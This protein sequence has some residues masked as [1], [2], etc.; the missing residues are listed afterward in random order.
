MRIKRH[1]LHIGLAVALVLVLL[2]NIASLLWYGKVSVAASG[3]TPF[4]VVIANQVLTQNETKKLR[5]GTYAA[6]IRG[7]RVAKIEQKITVG[8]FSTT[9]ISNAVPALTNE[10]LIANLTGIAKENLKLYAVEFF[11]EE[12]WLVASVGL[13][14]E[15]SDTIPV[16]AKYA[17]GEWVSIDSGTG[18]EY[19]D[20]VGLPSNVRTYLENRSNNE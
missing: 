8:A 16:I 1:Q 6:T 5:P 13:L 11:N 19:G 10:D 20:I 15:P 18:I 4:E 17:A 12:T 7:K 9:T 14:N 3:T 2:L